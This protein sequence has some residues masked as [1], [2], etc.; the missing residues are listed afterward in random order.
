MR[1]AVRLNP[2]RPEAHVWLA[3][4]YRVN[5]QLAEAARELAAAAP[6]AASLAALYT[7]VQVEYHLEEG[8]VRLAQG[9]LDDAAAAFEKVLALDGTNA[10]ARDKLAEV[11]K[12][13]QQRPAG[14]TTGKDK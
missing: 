2:S 13:R 9:R 12:R 10:A 1:E 3:R 4:A 11:A 7:N 6:S 14:K 8:L 5:G